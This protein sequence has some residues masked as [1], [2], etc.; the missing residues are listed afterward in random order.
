MMNCNGVDKNNTSDEFQMNAKTERNGIPDC[1]GPSDHTEGGAEL[2]ARQDLTSSFVHLDEDDGSEC[3]G[4]KENSS[5]VGLQ[6][7]GI[8]GETQ[9]FNGPWFWAG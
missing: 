7:V 3:A 8:R 5:S 2:A 1:S 6:S 9:S 4:Q